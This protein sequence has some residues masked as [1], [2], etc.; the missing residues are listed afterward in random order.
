MKKTDTP[1]A[2]PTALSESDLS[3]IIGMA[4]SD[5]TPFEAIRLQFG[6]S[7]GEVIAL[8]RNQLKI[9]SF[10]LWRQRVRGRTAKHGGRQ[11]MSLQLQTHPPHSS[12]QMMATVDLQEKNF[13]VPTSALTPAS[14]R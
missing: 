8:M 12:V 2:L 7:E 6:L 10:R 1:C 9:R 5:D 13:P 11:K 4:W 3:S 14:L